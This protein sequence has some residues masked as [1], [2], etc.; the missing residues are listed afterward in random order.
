LLARWHADV[1]VL[2][3]ELA[4]VDDDKASAETHLRAALETDDDHA[5]AHHLLARLLEERDA[6]DEMIAHDVRVHAL[7][8]RAD[9]RAQLGNA[10]DLAFIEDEAR[11]ALEALPPELADRVADV[12]VVLEPR[13]SLAL[14]REGFDPRALGLFEGPTDHARRVGDVDGRPTRI[15]LYYANLLVVASDDDA[16]AEQIEITVLHEIGHYFG[17]DEDQ[18]ADLGLA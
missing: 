18:V 11:R 17:L 7:D 2:Q 9:R 16:L 8:G 14:V 4:L 13:P 5:D 10:D 12:P 1:R 6:R 15:V 3:A